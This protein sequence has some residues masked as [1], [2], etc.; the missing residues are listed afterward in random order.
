M[1]IVNTWLLSFIHILHLNT[2]QKWNC[3]H[4]R[5]FLCG[6]DHVKL[7]SIRHGRDS[8]EL[9][10]AAWCSYA[11]HSPAPAAPAPGM[12]S[13]QQHLGAAVPWDVPYLKLHSREPVA[14][15]FSNSCWQSRGQGSSMCLHCGILES[16]RPSWA[17]TMPSSTRTGTWLS[18]IHFNLQELFHVPSLYP[19]VSS[20]LLISQL[21]VGLIPY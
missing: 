9:G 20:L 18:G 11:C 15:C 19:L 13:G 7:F 17:I 6:E 1:L 5:F 2:L 14:S 16:S 3:A 12:Y 10:S 4:C 21:F 8:G